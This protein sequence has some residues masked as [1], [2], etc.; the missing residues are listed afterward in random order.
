MEIMTLEDL[1]EK[2]LDLQPAAKSLNETLVRKGSR[3]S[4]MTVAKLHRRLGHPGR[5]RLVQAVQEYGLGHNS[6]RAAQG[7]KCALCEAHSVSKLSTPALM[8]KASAFNDV[9]GF[10]IMW[11]DVKYNVL[12]IMDAFNRFEQMGVLK[13]E[14][15]E[16]EIEVLENPAHVRHV[17]DR[18]LER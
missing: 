15:P 13:D 9:D 10:V 3:S 12:A 1:S 6:L 14:H 5:D 16:T 2:V 11:K 7:Y 8:H 4:L 17:C 18:F